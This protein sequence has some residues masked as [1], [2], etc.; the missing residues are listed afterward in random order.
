MKNLIRLGALLITVSAAA[1]CEVDAGVGLTGDDGD[2]GGTCD[3]VSCQDALS[4]GLSSGDQA[5]C[6]A[7]SD[8]DYA[9]LQACG[10]GDGSGPCD[11]VCSDNMCAD[12][13]ETSDC[14]DCLDQNC[15]GEHDTCAAN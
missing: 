15:G 7:S 12:L 8:S 14:G 9:A 10:C 1:A 11:D 5:I 13:G 3:D 4:G 6:D 2:N